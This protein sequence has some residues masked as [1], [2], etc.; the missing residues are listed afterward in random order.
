MK[1]AAID[2]GT[3]SIH[4]IVV[5]IGADVSF[6]VVDRAKEMVRLGT[7][8]LEGGV[9]TASSIASA[10]DTLVRFKRIADSRGVEEVI[11]TA[12]SA[13]RESHNGADFV[14]EVARQ[15]QIELGQ[16]KDRVSAM[17][18]GKEALKPY[19]N[20]IQVDITTEGLR[21]Q[22]V[23][24]QNRPMFDVG[25]AVLKEYTRE[26]LRSIGVVLNDANYK[27]SLAGHTDAQP[28]ASGERGYSNWEL[29]ADRANASRRELVLAGMDER[30]IVRVVG[31]ASSTLF[32]K[33]DPFNPSNR[34]ISI[35]VMNK[36]TE[37][38]LMRDGASVDISSAEEVESAV[39]SRR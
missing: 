24:A 4:M 26:I 19:R 21:I 38:A 13:V 28:Y 1:I 2:I 12:T 27:I 5:R 30:K 6:E 8:S 36:K 17:L 22:I 10:L 9:L 15:D 16:L 18:D 39:P 23:D 7:G 14:A 33:T 32:D 25:R 20:Q 3:N 31:L 11:A 35:V 29:S 34:R 37:E